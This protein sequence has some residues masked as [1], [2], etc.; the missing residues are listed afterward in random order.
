MRTR[1]CKISNTTVRPTKI[2]PARVSAFEVLSKI[3]TERAFSS[4]LLPTHGSRLNDLDRNLCYELTLGVLRKQI[5]LDRLITELSKN[6]K[7]DSAV[8]IAL[9]LGIYQLLFLDRIPAYSAIN[10]SVEL[11]ARARKTSAKGFVNAILRRISKGNVEI[12]YADNVDKI[13]VETSHPR[14]L[15][16]HWASVFG[17][18]GAFSVAEANNLPPGL[19][20]RLTA[21]ASSGRLENP[22]EWK[23]CS[24]V[25]GC[26]SV[27]RASPSLIRLAESGEI[28]FQDE[29]SQLVASAIRLGVNERFL[30]VCAAP[31]SKTTMIASGSSDRSALIVAGDLHRRRVGTLQDN[32]IT[33]GVKHVNF[34]QYDASRE[35]PFAEGS[36]DVVLV[37]APCSG[38]G[39][40]AHNPEIRYFLAH[41]DFQEFQRKQLSILGNASKMVKPKGRLVYSTCSLE[42]DE[43]EE[44]CEIFISNSGLF[45]SVKPA[46]PD[47]FLTS[48]NFARTF[49]PRD[50]MDGFFI[51]EFK[52]AA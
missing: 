24:H 14:W 22:D 25:E 1:S 43:N 19:T 46:V 9:R 44:V 8:A 7:L 13:S 30:D 35:L 33:Q 51:A 12:H 17:L 34:V 40:I 20:F 5:Y 41:G 48:E 6:K 15:I 10:E 49:P 21:K 16:E 29:G 47:R 26:V 11:V 39:T 36:F 52:R 37:D 38:T 45:S 42:R 4:I 23:P 28:Y 27:D 3:E 50:R 31:G 18:K 2:S 32:C